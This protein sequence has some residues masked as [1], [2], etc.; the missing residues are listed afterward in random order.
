MKPVAGA[1]PCPSNGHKYNGQ[2]VHLT[3]PGILP[4][5]VEDDG[6]YR[7]ARVSAPQRYW[8]VGCA[9]APAGRRAGR[10]DAH[11]KRVVV[12][13]GEHRHLKEFRAKVCRETEMAVEA[14]PDGANGPIKGTPRVS[15]RLSR[16]LPPPLPTVKT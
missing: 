6:V 8:P 4:T 10:D 5:L 1:P 9:P 15:P 3:E 2:P 16:C 14:R 13:D 12:L 7:Q 11:K